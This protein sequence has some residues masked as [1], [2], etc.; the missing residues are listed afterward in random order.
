MVL[1]NYM[2]RVARESRCPLRVWDI[3]IFTG[4]ISCQYAVIVCCIVSNCAILGETER[5]AFILSIHKCRDSLL[6]SLA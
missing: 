5:G 4:K 1:D 2:L 3:L 6:G